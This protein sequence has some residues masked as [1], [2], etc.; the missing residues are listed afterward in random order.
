M[1]EI[2]HLTASRPRAVGECCQV[3]V[4]LD[5]WVDGLIRVVVVVSRLALCVANCYRKNVLL[6]LSPASLPSSGRGNPS[7]VEGKRLHPPPRYTDVFRQSGPV[8][9]SWKVI[10]PEEE[11]GDGKLSEIS[12]FRWHFFAARISVGPGQLRRRCRPRP[13]ASAP[14]WGNFG[15]N[16]NCPCVIVVCSQVAG[17]WGH[18]SRLRPDGRTNSVVILK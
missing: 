11:D 6:L 9:F 16:A 10:W 7:A 1:I 2:I 15:L 14:L 8:K 17:P 18:I 13:G 12:D 4:D 5:S 3:V